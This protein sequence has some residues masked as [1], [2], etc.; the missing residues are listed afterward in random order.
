MNDSIA[1]SSSTIANDLLAFTES[2]NQSWPAVGAKLAQAGIS[3]TPE[4]FD[5]LIASW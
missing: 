4:Q 1:Q 3:L 5:S 2:L